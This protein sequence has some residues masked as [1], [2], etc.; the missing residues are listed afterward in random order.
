MR[1]GVWKLVVQHPKANPGTFDNGVAQLFK[2]DSDPSEKTDLAFR[3]SKRAV[4][5][6][7]QLKAW[8]AETQMTATKQPGGWLAKKQ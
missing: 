3:E 1:D 2:L 8:Y 5:M 7:K 4:K 6:S